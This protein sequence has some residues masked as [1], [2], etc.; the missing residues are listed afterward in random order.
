[1]D[2]SI[3]MQPQ[4]QQ[5]EIN[6]KSSTSESSIHHQSQISH[7]HQSQQQ[8]TSSHYQPQ[9]QR[10]R[11][12]SSNSKND[13]SPNKPTN[14]SISPSATNSRFSTPGARSLPLTPPS[15]PFSIQTPPAAA[16]SCPD[17]LAHALS[18]QNLRLQQIVYENRLREEALQRELYA[19]RLALLEKTCHHCSNQ[20]YGNDDPASLVDS[21][22][23]N[24]SN[25]SWEA[26]DE[27]S[28]PSSGANSSQQ[29][30]GSVLW[31]PDHAVSRCTT[32]Q[33]EFWLG[34]RKH[35][36]RSC[37]QIFCA[38]CSEYWAPLSDGKTVRLCEPCYQN[39]CG[40]M[41]NSHQPSTSGSV[42]VNNTTTNNYNSNSMNGSILVATKQHNASSSSCVNQLS[43]GSSHATHVLMTTV[44]TA[45]VSGMPKNLEHCKHIVTAVTSTSCGVSANSGSDR[46]ACK[47]TTATN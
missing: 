33:T 12:N 3:I 19:T 25:C 36:C 40:K 4:F 13:M 20:Q 16:L 31:V 38:D 21:M 29:I 35:H 41:T 1:M 17:G 14:G 46:E 32:C 42:I 47:A 30:T 23:E 10:R 27:R 37:G 39:V 15:V 44:S 18:E 34:R 6:G 2:E 26:V 28:A 43:S 5:L 45:P 24:A 22:N 11:R 8:H 7:Q 9:N